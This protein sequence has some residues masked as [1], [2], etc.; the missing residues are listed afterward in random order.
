VPQL[1]ART[2]VW[3]NPDLRSRNYFIPG[4][5]VNI[6]TLVTLSLTAMAIVREK[7]IGTSAVD[8]N[9][10]SPMSSFWERRSL[11]GGRLLGPAL[12]VTS[13]VFFQ[14]PFNG[15]FLLLLCGIVFLLT[16]LEQACS[17]QPSRCS[18]RP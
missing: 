7:E 15:S 8:G 12:V 17:C 16:T 13:R 1:A 10:H 4:V 11:P 9:A 6:I 18:G 14:V 5:V 2:H 3:Y